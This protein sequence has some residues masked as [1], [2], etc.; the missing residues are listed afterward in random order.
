MIRLDIKKDTFRKY[1]VEMGFNYNIEQYDEFIKTIQGI[2]RRSLLNDIGGTT[3]EDNVDLIFGNSK[4]VDIKLFSNPKLLKNISK[5]YLLKLVNE[6]SLDSFLKDSRK[7]AYSKNIQKYAYALTKIKNIQFEDR[8]LAYFFESINKYKIKAEPKITAL[9]C[10][11]EG[12]ILLSTIEKDE[13]DDLIISAFMDSLDRRFTLDASKVINNIQKLNGKIDNLVYTVSQNKNILNDFIINDISEIEKVNS[14]VFDDDNL[15]KDLDYL[16]KIKDI[17]VEKLS[18]P[19]HQVVAIIKAILS[20]DYKD[21]ERLLQYRHS[22]LMIT[23]NRLE[24]INDF[25]H[26]DGIPE[27]FEE[28]GEEF[29]NFKYKEIEHY[30]FKITFNNQERNFRYVNIS[31]KY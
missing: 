23:R 15:E 8:Q 16:N 26:I 25:Y 14:F 13:I 1:F 24:I 3:F 7:T 6:G 4:N 21:V 12:G 29:L 27:L 9:K 11:N 20:D 18:L 10:I 17:G 30:T 31:V 22:Q 5:K 19:T 28:L 2:A